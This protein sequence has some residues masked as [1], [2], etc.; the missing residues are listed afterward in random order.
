MPNTSPSHGVDHHPPQTTRR[1]RSRLLAG[2]STAV[3]G[4]VVTLLPVA[5]AT[6]DTPTPSGAPIAAPAGG[7]FFDV[8]G[9][10]LAVYRD[11]CGKTTVKMTALGD[12][13]GTGTWSGRWSADLTIRDR[14]GYVT[15]GYYDTYSTSR[16]KTLSLC[17]GIDTAGKYRARV[18]WVQYN[19]ADKEI[20]AGTTVDTFRF[21]IKPRARTTLKVDKKPYGTT[22]W[23][24]TGTL[25]RLRKP[26]KWQ[27]VSLWM[28]YNG[29]WVNYDATKTTNRR[30]RVSWHTRPD[31][32]PNRF[33]FQLRY[34][35]N[36]TSK[37]ARSDNFRLSGR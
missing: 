11:Q 14:Y 34:K 12:A 19:D 6:A 31:L 29:S 24:F 15:S 21:R 16:S 10:N 7:D 26:H 36:K 3:A 30:G 18:D 32:K 37:P 13:S 23:K 5:T 9:R 22:G 35:G 17:Q 25:K 8:T 1:T 27:R 20:A 28:R 33:L 2:V 4:L